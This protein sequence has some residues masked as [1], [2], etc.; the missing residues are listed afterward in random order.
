MNSVRKAPLI[1][2]IFEYHKNKIMVRRCLSSNTKPSLEEHKKNI[3]A[4]GLPKVKPINGVKHIV[5]VASGK[6]GVGKSTTSVNLAVSLK[7]LQP[8]KNVG[9][10]DA[11]VFGPSIPL[12]MNLKE[13]PLLTKDNLMKPLINYNIKCISMGFLVAEDAPVIW[14][15]LMVM[16]ALEKLLRQVFWDSIDYLIVDTPP[17]TGD[18]HLSLIQNIPISGVVLVTTSQTAALNVVK[19]GT[20]MFQQ[21]KVPIIGIVENMSSIKCPVCASNITL[22]GDDTSKMAKEF[23]IPVLDRIPLDQSITNSSDKGVPIVIAE[24]SSVEAEAYKNVGK[25]IIEFLEKNK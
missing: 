5:L 11:D 21:L 22:F 15:G 23:Q 3:M 4:R 8:E 9:L 16:Q 6:G 25:K 14:R 13:T 17:G 19:R 10:L 7:V 2:R 1:K 12:M 24:P 20:K 18:T